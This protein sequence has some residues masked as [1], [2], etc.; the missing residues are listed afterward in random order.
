MVPPGPLG[1]QSFIFSD[2]LTI[3]PD[4]MFLLNGCLA[5]ALLVG[6]SL[7]GVSNGSSSSSIIAT[8]PTPRISVS[9]PSPASC[10]LLFSVRI[11]VP[12]EPTVT[13]WADAI[14]AAMCITTVIYQALKPNGEI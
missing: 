1:Y 4:V 11:R 2:V 14:D 13:L 3:V 8:W 12:R 9:S 7:A 5:D 6:S 10:K